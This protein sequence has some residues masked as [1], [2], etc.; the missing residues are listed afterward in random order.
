VRGD[1]LQ[2]LVGAV[3]WV[4]VGSP[5]TKVRGVTEARALHVLVGDFGHQLGA[6]RLPR[7]ILQHHISKASFHSPDN[8]VIT[9]TDAN[10][11]YII[12]RSKMQKDI[13]R[14]CEE[15]GAQIVLNR[16]I[17]AVSKPG[18]SLRSISCANGDTFSARIVIDASGP[19]SSFGKGESIRWKAADLE[20]AYFAILDGVEIETD[21]VHIQVR[22]DLCP[23]GY[24]WI[25]PSE[26]SQAN[27][28][29]LVGS[30][31][32][33]TVNI[34]SLLEKFISE[35]F[36]QARIVRRYAGSIPCGYFKGPVAVEGLIKTGDAASTVNPIS[37]AGI[38]EALMSGGLAGDTSVKMLGVQKQS[39][40]NNLCKQYEKW[41]YEKRGKRHEK[42]AR[43]K[44]A[45]AA[46]PDADYDRAA[47]SLSEITQNKLT[48]AT[49]FKLSLGRFPKLVWAMR[50]L[51]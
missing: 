7:Q 41:W 25:F 21:A 35:H 44:S 1:H 9:Y 4:L 17:A 23:R 40:V 5:P 30:S 33:G 49:I 39:D 28:G 42:L 37:R 29:V 46:I 38:V 50:H 31:V 45:L 34:R 36:P 12:N 48:M 14:W 13:A 8:T 32:R 19:L 47:Q 51:M 16:A 22:N 43:A 24:A 11:G 26:G 6:Q 15:K 3:M 10:K 27:V 20:P 18:I 2:L